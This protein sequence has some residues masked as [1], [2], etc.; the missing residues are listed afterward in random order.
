M[1]MPETVRERLEVTWRRNW[2]SWLGG[3]G[4]WPLSV[5]LDPPTEQQ[6]RAQWPTFQLWSRTWAAPNWQGRLTTA[7]RTWSHLG[8]QEIPTHLLLESPAAVAELLGPATRQAWAAAEARW[9]DCTSRWPGLVDELRAIAGWLGALEEADY[10]RFCAAFEWLAAHSDS[11]LYV[12]QLPI[13]GLDSKW[14]EAH[15]GPLARLLAA[16]LERAPGHLAAVVGL[17]QDPIRRR[18]R[19]LD[20]ELRARFGGLSDL[21]VRLDELAALTM[22]VRVA[23]VI[24]NQQTAL[25]CEDVPG[26]VLLMGG[27]FS[28][29]ELRHL[30]WLSDVPIVYWGDIDT[31]GFAILSALRA[32]HPQTVSCLMDEATLLDHRELWSHET[33]GTSARVDHL[34]ESEASLYRCLQ[35]GRWGSGVRLEQERLNWSFAWVRLVEA[36][37]LALHRSSGT[38]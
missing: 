29:T 8:S 2:T 23:I 27:G 10:R 4:T 24:E 16:R 28:V 12:R 14:V 13:A 1:R 20:P 19:L 18:L 9:L 5:S 34:T 7:K 22:P 15:A 21:Q 17:A 31:A 33:V 11:G 3:G 26:A 38:H 37:A 25:A 30:P 32:W 36:A 6:A 35:T